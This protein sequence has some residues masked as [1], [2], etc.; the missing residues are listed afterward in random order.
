MHGGTY[1][2]RPS[3]FQELKTKVLQHELQII[4][5]ATTDIFHHVLYFSLPIGS[6]RIECGQGDTTGKRILFTPLSIEGSYEHTPTCYLCNKK[7][8][9]KVNS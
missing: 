9:I 5:E 7:G 8:H 2:V 3:Y 1:V 4:N 6:V